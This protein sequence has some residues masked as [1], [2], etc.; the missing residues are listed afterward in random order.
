MKC[1]SGFQAVILA[2]GSGSRLGDIKGE[3][4]KCLLNVGPYPL[5][6]FPLNMLW[7]NGFKGT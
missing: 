3:R 1:N 7:K 2:G 4:P 6:W 5:L